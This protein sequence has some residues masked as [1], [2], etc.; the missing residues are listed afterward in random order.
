MYSIVE[1]EAPQGKLWTSTDLTT[2]SQL[3]RF[4]PISARP[5][6][7][8]VCQLCSPFSAPRLLPVSLAHICSPSP[9]PNSHLSASKFLWESCKVPLQGHLGGICLCELVPGLGATW[10]PLAGRGQQEE[11]ELGHGF[12]DLNRFCALRPAW[13]QFSLSCS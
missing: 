3:I 8:C 10:G 9:G 4:V 12:R 5:W 2:E 1:R 13:L 6:E 7:L 11:G